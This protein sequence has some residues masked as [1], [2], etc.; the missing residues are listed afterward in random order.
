MACQ[1][2]RLTSQRRIFFA[3]TFSRIMST[4]IGCG[5]LGLPCR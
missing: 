2:R 5:A 1:I 3:Q 4:I